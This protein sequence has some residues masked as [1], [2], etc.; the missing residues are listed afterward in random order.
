MAVS[1]C[2]LFT[3]LVVCVRGQL[4]WERLHD[5]AGI[6]PSARVSMGFGYDLAS[7]KIIVFGGGPGP[8]NDTWIYDVTSGIWKEVV[9]TNGPEARFSMVSGF[10]NGNFYISTGE[11]A[12]KV[13]FNDI[14]RF[15]IL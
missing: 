11:G 13:F 2:V 10:S 12:N 14:W 9:V 7:N 15:D 4:E 3:V 6:A 5:G 8:M 1:T